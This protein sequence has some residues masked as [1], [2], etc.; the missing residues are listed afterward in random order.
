MNTFANF[1]PTLLVI[2][3]VAFTSGFVQNLVLNM[4]GVQNIANPSTQKLATAGIKSFVF[5]AMFAIGFA[6]IGNPYTLGSFLMV[7]A[8]IGLIEYILPTRPR[9]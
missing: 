1:L 8:F 2:L 9:S 5:A 7:W 3:V 4:F 6:L